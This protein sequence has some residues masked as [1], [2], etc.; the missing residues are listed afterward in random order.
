VSDYDPTDLRK[1][2]ADRAA[3]A[4][5]EQLLQEEESAD[6]RWLMG[7][8]RGRRIVWRLLEKSGLFSSTFDSNAMV[9]A[10]A[11]GRRFYGGRML[12]TIHTICP[13]LYPTMVKEQKQNDRDDVGSGQSA[14]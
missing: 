2:E 13:E 3:K 5:D 4:R 11:E 6:I 8:K 12:E 1:Q 7:S 14:H 9:M 10:F